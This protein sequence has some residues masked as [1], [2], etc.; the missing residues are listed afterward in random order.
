MSNQIL[1]VNRNALAPE[2][3]QEAAKEARSLR[4]N[5]QFL[6][7]AAAMYDDEATGISPFMQVKINQK[8][9]DAF[10][11]EAPAIASLLDE[12]TTIPTLLKGIQL[13]SLRSVF[14]LTINYCDSGTEV[15]PHRDYGNRHNDRVSRIATLC[16]RALFG[17]DV[18][19]G[20][21]PIEPIVVEAGDIHE[22]LNPRTLLERP[23]HWAR[24][25]G[26]TDRISFVYQENVIHSKEP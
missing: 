20:E 10:E 1:A 26:D 25:I 14:K 18:Q 8:N 24:T 23:V 11:S 16:G 22:L 5:I 12:M 19:S 13:A 9:R 2:I 21:A 3:I 7:F 15:A 4:E 6:G 17:I